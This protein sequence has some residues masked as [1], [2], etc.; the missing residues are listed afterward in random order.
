MK[1]LVICGSTD[2]VQVNIFKKMFANYN[3]LKCKE[4]DEEHIGGIDNG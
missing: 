4:N 2:N 3:R 1:I